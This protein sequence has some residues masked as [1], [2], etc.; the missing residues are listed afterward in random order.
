[1]LGRRSEK[2]VEPGRRQM[3]A[4]RPCALAPTSPVVIRFA[5]LGDLVMAIPSMRALAVRWGAPVTVVTKGEWG[6]ELFAGLPF[7]GDVFTA[8]SSHAP[9][10]FSPGQWALVRFLSR[11]RGRQIFL[12]ESGRKAGFFCRRG[13]IDLAGSIALSG[14][15]DNEHEVD[16][17]ARA[18]GVDGP[19]FRR[20]P[21][22]VVTDDER[23][24]CQ[25]WLMTLGL[26]A[27]PIVVHPGNSKTQ[28]GS[29]NNHKEWPMGRWVDLIGAVRSEH[30]EAPILI[31]GTLRERNLC[32]E[33]AAR[34][35]AGVTSVAGK[36]TL[37]QLMA[38]LRLAHGC[39]SVDTGPG[40]VAAALGCPLVVLFGKSDPRVYGPVAGKA[41]VRIVTG[42]PHAVELSGEAGWRLYHSMHEIPV[43]SV[44]SAWRSLGLGT[45]IQL[46]MSPIEA[47]NSV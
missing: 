40:H 43:E 39:I 29:R 21:E 45:Q 36:T 19:G 15:R 10:L 16:A 26:S 6:A 12:L 33:L 44:V 1:M 13:R 41:P 18:C 20:D 24:A 4:V 9:Y 28:R 23:R 14:R 30:S 47:V 5:R 34:A 35:G 46:G 3:E 38:L 42:P 27:A 8:V 17:N 37:R 11:S 22:L 25:R 31:T 2:R 32:V 7:V